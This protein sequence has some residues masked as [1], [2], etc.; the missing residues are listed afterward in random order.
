MLNQRHQLALQSVAALA[1]GV[2]DAQRLQPPLDLGLN[3]RG[4]LEQAGMV[5]RDMRLRHV[6]RRTGRRAGEFFEQ[7]IVAEG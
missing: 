7:V 5:V 1:G 6:N 2:R 4:I 3:Q